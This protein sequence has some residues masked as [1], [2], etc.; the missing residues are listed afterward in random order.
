MDGP[1]TVLTPERLARLRACKTELLALLRND[2]APESHQNGENCSA[3]VSGPAGGENCRLEAPAHLTSND[4]PHELSLAERV[5]T[6][7]VN[8]GWT[9]GAWAARLRQL[10]ERCEAFRPKLAGQYREWA[11]NVERAGG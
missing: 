2:E 8:P 4:V 5:E 3:P 9:P 6:G 10:A 7:Y 1:A 11:A